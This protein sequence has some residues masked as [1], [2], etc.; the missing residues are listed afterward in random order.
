VQKGNLQKTRDLRKWSR[1]RAHH[2]QHR[3]PHIGRGGAHEASL[4]TSGTATGWKHGR[5]P[6]AFFGN[7]I[8]LQSAP[9]PAIRLYPMRD[10]VSPPLARPQREPAALRACRDFA[11]SRIRC[12]WRLGPVC[13]RQTWSSPADDGMR[14]EGF[15]QKNLPWPLTASAPSA[16]P[17][18]PRPMVQPETGKRSTCFGDAAERRLNRVGAPSPARLQPIDEDPCLKQSQP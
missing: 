18:V 16:Q 4:Q 2:V 9:Q 7:P 14:N 13:F 12:S 1:W 5:G 6:S 17:D 11:R 8:V 15:P 3:V 10:P